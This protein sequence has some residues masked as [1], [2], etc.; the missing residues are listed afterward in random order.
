MAINNVSNQSQVTNKAAAPAPKAALQKQPAATMAQ[1][2]YVRRKAAV[3]AQAPARK[4]LHLDSPWSG[5]VSSAAGLAVAG[6][7]ALAASG[8]YGMG[9]E[10][11]GMLASLVFGPLAVLAIAGGAIGSVVIAY[12][13]KQRLES[14]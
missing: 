14:N 1:D 2:A 5:I 12:G 4:G 6:G 3:Q 13:L 10:A 7:A 8:L 9:A 11:G